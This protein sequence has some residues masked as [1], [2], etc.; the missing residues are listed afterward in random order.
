MTVS[1]SDKAKRF[2]ALHEAPGTFV[3]PN[4]WDAGSARMLATLGFQ[5][6]TT[7]S[8]ACAGTLGRRDGQVTRD[9]ALAH[10]RLIAAATALRNQVKECAVALPLLPIEVPQQ[11]E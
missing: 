8:G 6:L 11:A 4:P 10:C 2:R 7:S 5:A 3:I 1:Q 9:E